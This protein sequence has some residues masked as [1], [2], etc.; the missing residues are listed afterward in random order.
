MNNKMLIPVLL[1]LSIF[2]AACTEKTIPASNNSQNEQKQEQEQ[3]KLI[4]GQTD[5]HGCIGPAGYSWC[6]AKQKCLRPWE[7]Y[8]GASEKDPVFSFMNT[9]RTNYNT[10]FSY[11]EDKN[12]NWKVA[13]DSAP[14]DVDGLSMTSDNVTKANLQ[15]IQE[16]FIEQKF[17]EDPL[18]IASGTL[19]GVKGYK[20]DKMVCLNKTEF[21]SADSSTG[22]LTVSCGQLPADAK[23]TD[24]PTFSKKPPITQPLEIQELPAF[25]LET[26]LK[27]LFAQKYDKQMSDVTVDTSLQK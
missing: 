9:I 10:E 21:S 4:G 14:E 12:F 5:E 1:V 2:L 18:N 22:L 26:V 6:E 20:K 24:K 19:T 25:S 11:I 16:F 15:K 27:N 7:E 23:V 17:L 13:S 8:C 3:D